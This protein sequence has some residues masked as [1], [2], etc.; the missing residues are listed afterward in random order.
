VRAIPATIRITLPP[1]VTTKILKTRTNIRLLL[2][3][4]RARSMR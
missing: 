2:L 3:G 4:R 1:L